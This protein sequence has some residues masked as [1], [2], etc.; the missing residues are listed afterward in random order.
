MCLANL[1]TY[2]VN[3]INCS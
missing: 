3:S 2:Q 1:I